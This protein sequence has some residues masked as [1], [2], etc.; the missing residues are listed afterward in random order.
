MVD[1]IVMQLRFKLALKLWD[2]CKLCIRTCNPNLQAYTGI[3]LALQTC[4]PSV[5]IGRPIAYRRNQGFWVVL[6]L[7]PLVY[8]V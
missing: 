5:P 6:L 7:P 2:H 3:K 8:I 4:N 1:C